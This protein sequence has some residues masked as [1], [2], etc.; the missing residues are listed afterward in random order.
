M[1][2]IPIKGVVTEKGY[3]HFSRCRPRFYEQVKRIEGIELR[4]GTI[5]IRVNGAMPVPSR[6]AVRVEGL[7]DIDLSDN[8]D[9]LITPCRSNQYFGYWILPVFK[10]TQT[11]NPLGH[12]PD[13]T[14]EVSFADE[15]PNIKP[16]VELEL[17]L[18]DSTN[19]TYALVPG[20]SDQP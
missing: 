17:I 8:Q 20:K 5:N 13:Q 9:I 19:E 18:L 12:Y 7:D 14:I 2:A 6:E 1:P 3:G 10:G 11:P 15:L 16:G 4:P